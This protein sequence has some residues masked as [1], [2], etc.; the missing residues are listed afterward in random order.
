VFIILTRVTGLVNIVIIGF[1]AVFLNAFLDDIIPL[2]DGT[3]GFLL[4]FG[5]PLMLI[6]LFIVNVIK[7]F[8]GGE[9]EE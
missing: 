9:D 5:I 2:F 6:Y 3:V 8:G 4:E 7:L 1:M